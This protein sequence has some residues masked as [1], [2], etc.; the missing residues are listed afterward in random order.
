MFFTPNQIMKRKFSLLSLIVLSNPVLGADGLYYTGTEAQESFPI[1]WLL[2][3][4][5]VY[6]D[7]VNA[8]IQSS[9]GSDASMAISPDLGVSW[10]GANPQTTWDIYG[11]LGLIYYF[12]KPESLEDDTF[13]QSRLNASFNHRF[14]ERVRL[15]S[16]NYIANE[17][18]PEYSYGVASSRS[19]GESFTWMTDNSIGYRWT[20]RLGTFTGIRYSGNRSNT[21]EENDNDRTTIGFYEQFRYQLSPQTVLTPEYRYNQ[22]IGSGVASDSTDQFFVIGV[23]H[24]FSPN[25]VGI[26]KTGIQLRDVKEG[27]GGASPYLEIALRSKINQQ[28]NLAGYTR[29]SAEVNDTVLASGGASYDYEDRR[30]L[31]AGANARYTVSEDFSLLSGTDLIFSN[32]MN[33]RDVEDAGKY[34]PDKYE[35]NINVY[36]GCSYKMTDYLF[37]NLYYTYT[38]TFTDISDDREYV[39]NR[40]SLGLSA[41]F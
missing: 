10:S 5:A 17:L 13:S 24:R 23:D 30:A 41:E 39:R 18:E 36:V 16:R 7:N 38:Q 19:G 9:K 2:G 35:S 15:G 26:F 29:Y 27:D 33:G 25:T 37:C 32:Y 12:D 4:S 22:T 40:I 14:N 11:K 28:L 8:G 3:A 1:K 31:R 21:E 6:D 34:G 20:E